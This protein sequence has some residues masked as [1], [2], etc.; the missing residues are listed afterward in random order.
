METRSPDNEHP[1]IIALRHA[2]LEA[3]NRAEKSKAEW[4][5]IYDQHV[6][7]REEHRQLKHGYEQLRIQKGGFGFKMLLLAGFMGTIVALVACFL[8]LKLQ[9]KDSQTVAFEHFQR[10]HLFQYELAI[11]K[12]QFD[13]VEQSLRTELENPDNQVIK[14]E[15]VFIRQLVTTTKRHCK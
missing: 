14:P 4:S 11:S 6:A 2:L 5:T 12:G 9:P 10:E 1:E 8:Y 15:L 7:L 13:I 3:E